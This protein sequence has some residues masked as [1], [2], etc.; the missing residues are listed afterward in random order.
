MSGQMAEALLPWSQAWLRVAA[1]P[2]S[3]ATEPPALPGPLQTAKAGRV[4]SKNVAVMHRGRA[5][6]GC[7]G[8]SFYKYRRAPKHARATLDPKDCYRYFS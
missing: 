3:L 7:Y 1:A 2:E 8:T 4:N 5:V 6:F